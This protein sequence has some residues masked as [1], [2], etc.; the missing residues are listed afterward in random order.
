LEALP[1]PEPAL[2]EESEQNKKDRPPRRAR[3]RGR[4]DKRDKLD[5]VET[6]RTRKPIPQ[7]EE[8]PAEPEDNDLEDLPN[9][10]T[11]NVPS[12]N[13]LIASLYRPER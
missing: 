4:G 13:E 5:D 8:A 12:W 7:G 9:L 10:S 1:V 3:G 6:P 2:V 11:L